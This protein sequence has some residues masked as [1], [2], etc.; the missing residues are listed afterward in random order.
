MAK[1]PETCCYCSPSGWQCDQAAGES[2]L[3]YWHD[4]VID[5]SRDD[6]KEK[7]EAWAH[8]GRPLDGFQ[9][10]KTDLQHINLVNRGS[11]S[12]YSCRQADFYRANLSHAHFFKLDLQGSSLMKANLSGANLHCARLGDV[13]FLGV[14]LSKTRLENI[15]W[16]A[17]FKQEIEALKARSARDSA[18]EIALYQELEEVCRNIRKQ[19]E[20]QGLFEEAGRFFKREMRF[21]RYQ[22]PRL[23]LSRLISKIVD[24][25]CGY[26]EDPLRV[27]AFSIVVILSCAVSYYLL[28]T[29]I[30][31]PLYPNAQGWQKEVFEFMNSIYFSVVTFTT[32][33]YGD[34]SPHGFARFIAAFEAFMGSFTMA[35]FVVV[36]V[37]KMTR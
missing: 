7:V 15:E 19:C 8:S 10:A 26:G 21:R 27:V 14:E 32:L 36:F 1:Q 3:C 24:L 20:M 30:S 34:I 13:N 28:G 9:L 33:G 11:A 2:G 4:P 16:G 6:V 17:S 35:L 31:N 5:K 12:G 25:F 29:T 23:S 18:K 22:M 37:K